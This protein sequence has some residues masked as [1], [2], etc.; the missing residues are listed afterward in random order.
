MKPGGN[1]RLPAGCW[2]K[3]EWGKNS[4]SENPANAAL[5]AATFPNCRRVISFMDAIVLSKSKADYSGVEAT[6]K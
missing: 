5:A 6:P 4:G 3:D 1:C 2:A